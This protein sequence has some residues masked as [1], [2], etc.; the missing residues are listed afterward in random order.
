MT[1]AS[2][3]K[4]M[5]ALWDWGMFDGCFGNS[6]IKIGDID[7]IVES[8]GHFL[9]IEGKSVGVPIPEGQRIMI[10][11]LLEIPQFTIICLW[12]TPPNRINR[13]EVR[14]GKEVITIAHATIGDLRSVV[15]EWYAGTI[16]GPPKLAA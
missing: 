7:G 2:P 6:R 11:K 13:I 9:L 1:I 14:N 8:R 4:Y 5:R 3:E 15:A 12:G 10:G 16:H